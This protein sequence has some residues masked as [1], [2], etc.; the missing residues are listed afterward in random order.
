[1]KHIYFLFFSLLLI[2]CKNDSKNNYPAFTLVSENESGVTFQNKVE[3]REDFNVLT[4]RNYYNGGGVAIGDINNDGLNDIYFTSNIE[5]N[6]LYLNKGNMQ[7]EDITIKAGVAGKKSWCTGVTMA[8]VNDD[9]FL[10]LYVC[11][12]GD[13]KKENKE[14]QLFINNKDN[15]F[16]ERAKELG[17]NDDGLS[18]HASFFDYDLDGDLDCYVLNNSYK[19][20]ERIS[21]TTREKYDPVA[22]GGDRL[23]Q[24]NGGKFSNV[25]QKAGIFSSDAGFGLGISV[26]DVNS[27][28]YPDIYISNDFWEMDYLYL[29][30][31]NGTFIE[32]LTPS[33]SYTS[34][35]SMGSDIADINNDGNLDLFSTD[36]L[37][38]DNYRLKAATK[39]DDYYLYDLKFRQ[40]YYYQYTQNCLHLNQG[41]GK[42][43]E[44]SFISNIAATDWSWGALVFDLN[45]DGRK[46]IFVSNG[47]FHDITDSDF[48]DFISDEI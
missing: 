12:S 35:S 26:G 30:Q 4:Y 48:A 1:M 46:D 7:F 45:L 47:V 36:M 31:K 24:N 17:L 33:M 39:F 42:F 18:T 29:N 19:D 43:I 37:P 21:L 34:L 22:L 32:S 20:P 9:G 23:Y 2:A 14:N 3:D 15:T 40:S 27:D 28:G 38:P 11:Y 25:T 13:G 8:D 5:E 41:N 16:T 10:D 6:K 44:S